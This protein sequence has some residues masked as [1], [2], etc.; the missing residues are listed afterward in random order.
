MGGRLEDASNI[1]LSG[2]SSDPCVLLLISKAKHNRRWMHCVCGCDRVH[3]GGTSQRTGSEARMTSSYLRKVASTLR[4]YYTVLYCTGILIRS[5]CGS[6]PVVWTLRGCNIVCREVR[7]LNDIYLRLHAAVQ[8]GVKQSHCSSTPKVQLY[9]LTVST[10]PT[11]PY[12][13]DIHISPGGVL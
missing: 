5:T 6:T 8:L 10:G 1:L 4:H 12:P 13:D 3:V 2:N 7:T 9:C 11:G